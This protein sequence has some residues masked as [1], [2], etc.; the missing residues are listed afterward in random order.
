MENMWKSN[1]NESWVLSLLVITVN[2]RN[3]ALNN[4]ENIPILKT[5]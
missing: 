2:Y 3:F 1:L 4:E 5:N